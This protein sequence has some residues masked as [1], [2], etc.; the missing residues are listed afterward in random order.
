MAPEFT[1]QELNTICNWAMDA[2]D[3]ARRVLAFWPEP[4]EEA[5]AIFNKAHEEYMKR[6]REG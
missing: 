3:K 4:Y 5:K 1:T 2:A 6:E